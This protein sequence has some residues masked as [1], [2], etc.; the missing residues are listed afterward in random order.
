MNLVQVGRDRP[1]HVGDAWVVGVAGQ[2][3][4]MEMEDLLPR[5]GTRIAQDVA[6]RGSQPFLQ[7]VTYG[8]DGRG[9]LS[10]RSRVLQ[11]VFHVT[12][13]DDQGVALLPRVDVEERDCGLVLIDP[14]RRDLALDHPAEQ[15]TPHGPHTPRTSKPAAA[16]S[17]LTSTI[18]SR[19]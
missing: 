11:D 12:A 9:D 3:V 7:Q 18:V 8:A 4:D 13:R 5:V 6:G 16:S 2:D 14:L 10:K 1:S 17:C 19:P 15:A